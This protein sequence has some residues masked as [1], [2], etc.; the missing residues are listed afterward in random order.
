MTAGRDGFIPPFMDLRTLSAHICCSES[1]IENWIA[2]GQFPGPVK[3][4]GKKKIW[5]WGEVESHLASHP[6]TG[7]NPDPLADRIR[8]A[9]KAAADEQERG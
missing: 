7:D 4:L 8:R 6:L 5:S 9:T 1:A 2:L 3:R